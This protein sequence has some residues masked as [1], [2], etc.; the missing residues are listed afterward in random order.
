MGV[1][2]KVVAGINFM[3]TSNILLLMRFLTIEQ[4]EN[5]VASSLRWGKRFGD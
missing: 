2:F 5:G 4:L 1:L 3:A